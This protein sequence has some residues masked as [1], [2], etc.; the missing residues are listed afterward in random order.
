MFKKNILLF[1]LPFYLFSQAPAID[2]IK[3]YGGTGLDLFRNMIKTQDGG[4]LIGGRSKSGISGNK[5]EPL[6]GYNDDYWVLKLDLNGNIQWQKAVGGGGTWALTDIPGEQFTSAS[7]AIDGS[8]YLAGSSPSPVIEDKSEPRFGTTIDYNDFWIVK[9]SETGQKLWDRTLGGTDEDRCNAVAATPDGGCVAVGL[10]YS[11]LSGNKTESNRGINDYW[12]V[13]LSATGSIEW[14]R[15]LGGI[16]SEVANDVYANA[17]GSIL[18]AGNSNSDISGDKTEPSKGGS[19]IW[20]IKLDANGVLL[21]QKVLGGSGGDGVYAV[22]KT[23][24]GYMLGCTS[25]SNISGDKSENCRGNSDYWLIKIDE[26]ATVIWDRTY[27][28]NGL[29]YIWGMDTFSDG[30]IVMVGFSESHISGEKTENVY[31]GSGSDGW[32]VRVDANGNILWDKDI[33]RSEGSDGLFKVLVL[34]N[35]TIYTGT[36]LYSE[37]SGNIT[38]PGYGGVNYFLIKMQQETLSNAVSKNYCSVVFYPNPVKDNV[39]LKFNENQDRVH[40]VLYNYLSQKVFEKSYQNKSE[41]QIELPKTKGIYF[42]EVLHDNG[43][44]QTAKILKE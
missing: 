20:L 23:T 12:V 39:N 28:G 9:L 30:G 3:P 6:K 34:P 44:K 26:N 33:G 14:Q 7:Q 2:W 41:I 19:D 40:V 29:D 1:F 27:G 32:M 11:G 38:V 21:W 22:S 16:G 25:Y 31:G 10:S 43:L 18:I 5:T 36:T 15:T 35:N 17:D 24:N 42:V 13:K 8:Y 37:P 4:M